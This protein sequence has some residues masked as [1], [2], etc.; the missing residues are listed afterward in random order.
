[1][2]ERSSRKRKL[3]SLNT[4]EHKHAAGTSARTLE[5][6]VVQGNGGIAAAGR[7]RGARGGGPEGR[8]GDVGWHDRSG[9]SLVASGSKKSRR[10]ESDGRGR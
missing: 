9:G 3:E 8:G 4:H 10:A 6:R 5:E 1:M 7:K 2:K